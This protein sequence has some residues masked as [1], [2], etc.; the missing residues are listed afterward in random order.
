MTDD[1]PNEVAQPERVGG[2]RLEAVLGKGAMGVVYR[3][4]DDAGV[5][6][7]IKVLAERLAGDDVFRHRFAHEAR[8]ATELSHKHLVPVLASGESD[9]VPFLVMPLV[10]GGSLAGLLQRDGPMAGPRV[11]RLV[12]QIGGA[13]DAIHT[14]GMVHRDVKPSNIL[15]DDAGSAALTDFGIAKGRAYTVLT[16]SGQP[17]GTLDYMAPELVE[18]GAATPASDVYALGCVAYESITGAPPFAQR[19]VFELA[20]SHL[21]EPPPDP[22]ASGTGLSDGAV[23]SLL[24]A[25]AKSPSDRPSTATMYANMLKL[26]MR[27]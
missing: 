19:G 10:E 16:Q 24:S 3:A 11:A 9:G 14:T 17:L 1:S 20:R 6:V 13:L 25:L 22:R 5:A 7:A 12:A 21:Q 2:Y 27:R 4:V 23:W 18:G 26:A 8:A 15:V